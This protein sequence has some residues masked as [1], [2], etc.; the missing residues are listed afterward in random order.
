MGATMED[1]IPVRWLSRW[2]KAGLWLLLFLVVAFGVV[3]EKRTAFMSRRMGDLG[4]YLRGAWAVRVGG[5]LYAVMDDNGWHYNYPPLLAILMAPLA[6]PPFEADHTGMMPYAVAAGLWY[7]LNILA[8]ALGVHWLASA[9]ERTSALPALRQQP[10]G[11]RGWWVLRVAPVLL[12]LPMVGHTLMRGQVNLLMLA[13]LCGIGAGLLLGQRFR[14]G[15]C[16]AGMICVKVFPAY[17]LVYPLWRRDLRCLV[18]CGAGLFVGLVALPLAVFGPE[19]TV[20]HYRT[21]AK[22]LVGPALGARGDES[23]TK[24]L[25]EEPAT[26][27]QAFYAVL[28]NTL[29]FD[30]ATRP[31]HAEPWVR[32]AHWIIG[33]VLTLLALLA[34]R[35]RTDSTGT[36]M[37]LGALAVIMLLLCPVCHLHNLAVCAFL[38]MA[39]IAADWERHGLRFGWGLIGV[40]TVYVTLNVIPQLPRFE[41]TRDVGLAMYGAL[42]LWLTAVV[43][44]RQGDAARPAP[45]LVL[46]GMA[47]AA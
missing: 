33:G 27:T 11:S 23:R 26:D 38:V 6:D 36:A 17:L 14:A 44:L 25:T 4:C 32:S 1:T 34:G 46:E 47:R 42:L 35:P 8:L 9:L 45:A 29:N 41:L 21:W 19:Q 24:E 3:V 12:C 30:R 40:F 2:E 15:L 22:V 43:K 18:G 7:V 39:L 5:D 28:H 20:Q 13:L 10:V 37:Q 31:V 16:L